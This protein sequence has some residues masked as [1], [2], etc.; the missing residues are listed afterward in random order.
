MIL[1]SVEREFLFAIRRA[2]RQPHNRMALVLHLSRLPTARA[3]HHR[4]AR[5]MLQDAAQRLEGQMFALQGG[6]LALLCRSH[7]TAADL[8]RPTSP[9]PYN[10][11]E[12]LGRLFHVAPATLVTTWDLAS[13]LHRLIGYAEERMAAAAAPPPEPVGADAPGLG[14][15][16]VI[17]AMVNLLVQSRIADLMHRQTAIRLPSGGSAL[18]PAFR[19]VTFSIATL[20][21]RIA[22]QNRAARQPTA[23]ATADP[24]LFRFLATRLDTYLLQGL[25]AEI[26]S[27]SP[28]DII[29]PAAAGLPLHVNISLAA[30]RSDEFS[31][32]VALCRYHKAKLGIEVSYLD[33]CSDPQE[34][35]RVRRLTSEAG[36]TLVL[37]SITP[38]ALTL[39]RPWNLTSAA[40]RPDLYKLD[41]TPAPSGETATE[42]AA[43]ARALEQLGPD[44]IV[45]QRT[46]NEAALTWGV[47]HGIRLFQG[48]QIEAMLGAGRMIGCPRSAACTLRQC[49]ERASA[50]A[51]S[52]RAGCT[53]LP[54][55]DSGRARPLAVQAAGA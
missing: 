54:L 23:D 41:W 40:A 39:S 31:R 17:D 25:I 14:A 16:A 19:E 11:P 28:L 22:L 51:R 44:R 53:N 26:G 6:D 8:D 32:F 20:Q 21:T 49:I 48:R 13:E 52:G 12:A 27:R 3:H 1:P 46:E 36:L 42:R 45:L 2:A 10:L 9:S 30:I 47:S 35:Q 24:Y 38:L 43:L 55:L 37:D 33:A 15:P 18:Q 34:F 4:V 50:I 5:A 29:A 7:D